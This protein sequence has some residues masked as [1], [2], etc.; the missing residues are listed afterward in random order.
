MGHDAALAA[1]PFP[2][3]EA[4]QVEHQGGR[5]DG[6][7]ALPGELHHHLRAEE[8]LEVDVVPGGLPVVERFNVLDGAVGGASVDDDEFQVVETRV[9]AFD[10]LVHGVRDT[11][12]VRPRLP[13]DP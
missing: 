4:D 11:D 5:Q 6:I 13:D 12:R 10:R 3:G 7:A 8:A 9:D 2:F 1:A